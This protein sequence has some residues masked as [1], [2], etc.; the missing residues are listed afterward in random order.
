MLSVNDRFLDLAGIKI[1]AS[2]VT[3]EDF[4]WKNLKRESELSDALVKSGGVKEAVT[5]YFHPLKLEWMQAVAVKFSHHSSV[6][7]GQPLE[8]ADQPLIYTLMMDVSHLWGARPAF[9]AWN[10]LSHM[11][12]EKDRV[13]LTGGDSLSRNDLIC[14]SYYLE[15]RSQNEIAQFMNQSVKTVERRIGGIKTSLLSISPECDTLYAVCRKHGIRNLL[16]IKR[17]WFDKKSVA[18]EISN[19]QWQSF[20]EWKDGYLKDG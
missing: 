13:R 15:D 16:E 20:I 2:T 14:L 18:L 3:S 5:L 10:A 1:P 6:A 9:M 7:S 8:C 19:M 11:D 17:D 12:Y 4:P